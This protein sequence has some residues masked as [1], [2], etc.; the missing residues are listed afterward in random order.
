LK[1]AFEIASREHPNVILIAKSVED[2]NNWM[3]DLM[4]L[5]TR[6]VL[7][8][9]LDSILLEEEKNYPLRLPPAHLYKFAE[10]DSEENIILET[11]KNGVP[12]IKGATLIK[13]V[14]RLT[15]H[16]YADPTS[17]KILLITYR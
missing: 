2:K 7:E 12:L 11:R 16:T 14:E 5:Y 1:N 10:Q 9:T 17:V 6:S 15:H 8:K 13:L 3:A 4:M